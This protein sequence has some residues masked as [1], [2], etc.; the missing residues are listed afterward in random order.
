MQFTTEHEQIRRTLRTDCI[1]RRLGG[2][3]LTNAWVDVTAFRDLA[4]EARV[5][6]RSGDHA[7]V[8]GLTR[9]AEALYLGDFEAHDGGS[10]WAVETTPACCPASRAI[11]RSG[12]QRSSS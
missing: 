4:V 1:A 8:V 6:R 11:A 10:S 9:E 7:R 5:S 2:L 12:G 3:V